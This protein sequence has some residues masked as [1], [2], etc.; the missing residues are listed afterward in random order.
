LHKK[1]VKNFAPEAHPAKNGKNKKKTKSRFCFELFNCSTTNPKPKDLTKT[2]FLVE[3]NGAIM[4]S[5]TDPERLEKEIL[6]KCAKNATCRK[7]VQE[8]DEEDITAA[9]LRLPKLEEIKLARITNSEN[10]CFAFFVITEA[11]KRRLQ[12]S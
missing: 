11:G 7:Q 8:G 2:I 10:T 6:Q 12:A 5:E 4:K 9:F 1:I 3:K